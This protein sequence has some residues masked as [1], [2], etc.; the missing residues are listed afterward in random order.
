VPVEDV[1]AALRVPAP[2]RLFPQRID[3]AAQLP[4]SGVRP[5]EVLPRAQQSRDQER[6][7]DQIAAVV[8]EPRDQAVDA[9]LMSATTTTN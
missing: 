9:P 5:I 2:F 8:L 7:L 4:F 1:A 3:A 6:R